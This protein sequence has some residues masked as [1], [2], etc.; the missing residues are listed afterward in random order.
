MNIV[1]LYKKA[2]AAALAAVVV[3]GALPLAAFAEDTAEDTSPKVV[4]ITEENFPDYSFRRGISYTYD[5]NKD[6][7]LSENEIKNATTMYNG[8]SVVDYTGVEYFTELELFKI[9][10]GTNT[11]QLDLSKNTKLTEIDIGTTKISSIDLSKNTELKELRFV[12]SPKLT[13]LDL[14][15]NTK[16]QTL[17]CRDNAITSLDLSKNPELTHIEC[18]RNQISNFNITGCTK[19]EKIRCSENRISDIYDLT[20]MTN[21][22]Q[23]MF[24]KNP[25]AS[26]KV[27]GLTELT[28]VNL[29]GNGLSTFSVKNCPNLTNLDLE[30]NNL[31]SIFAENCPLNNLVL[32]DNQ[33]T[34]IDNI[35]TTKIESL[36]IDNNKL[37]HLNTSNYSQL[38]LLWCENNEISSLDLSNNPLLY[39]LICCGNKLTRLEINDTQRKLEAVRC[40]DNPIGELKLTSSKLGVVWCDNAKLSSVNITAPNLRELHL[41]NNYITE[42]DISGYQLLTDIY[43]RNNKLTKLDLSHNSEEL[44]RVFCE[45]NYIT[46]IDAS[47]NKLLTR[48]YSSD[49]YCIWAKGNTFKIELDENGQYDL[50][51]LTAI[52]GFDVNRASDWKGGTVDGNILTVTPGAKEVTYTY[53][54]KPETAEK[55]ALIE[56]FTLLPPKTECLHT[57]TSVVGAKAATC[58]DKGFTGNTVCN[59]CKEIV[60][61]GTEIAVNPNYHKG[62][63]SVI[64]KKDATCTAKG[65]TGDTKCNDCGAILKKGTEI[66]AKGHSL[67]TVVTKATAAKDGSI[68]KVCKNCKQTV[69]K[70]TIAKVSNIKVNTASYVYNG[71]VKTPAVTVKDSKGKTLRKNTDYTVTYAKGRKNVGKYKVTV[72]LKGNYSGTKTLSFTI[73]PKGTKLSS[74]KAGKKQ[75]TVKWKAQKK[76]TTGYQVQYSTSKKFKGAKIATIKKN[77]TTSATIKKLK[78][79]KKYYVRVR[80][81]KTVGKAK[82]YSAWSNAKNAKAKK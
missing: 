7:W 13:S 63:T 15:K 41:E 32:S 6:D 38:D 47:T 21:L 79:G 78:G 36:K 16:L 64:N 44:M 72:T 74:V 11:K 59:D 81:Y 39:W 82:Y 57:N 12:D 24:Y 69:S 75:V 37:T 56:T 2:A 29:N 42:L 25:G 48:T 35:N 10:N 50:S 14:S 5:L 46:A 73:V 70:T 22:Q 33:L 18:S 67:N 53:T 52:S 76:S 77:K 31:T 45:N 65:Y 28:D 68:A 27:D 61:S 17:E 26:V 34:N 3:L 60:V 80:T 51:K 9:T 55:A 43:C 19:L 49:Y 58:K 30:N 4:E 66:A 20:G 1:G 40:S 8:L 54:M 23:A 71:K 62:A